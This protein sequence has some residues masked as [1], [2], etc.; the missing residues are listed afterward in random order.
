MSEHIRAA[1]EHRLPK[2]IPRG[3][4]WIETRVFAER[5]MEDTIYGHIALYREMEMDFISIP[6]TLSEDSVFSYRMFNPSEIREAAESGLFVLAVVDG[7]FQMLVNR[8]GLRRTL[9]DIAG[10]IDE[11]SET[12]SNEAQKVSS[13]VDTCIH[14]GANAVMIAED[15]AYDRG[16]FFSPTTFRNLLYPAYRD[17]M[18]TIHNC[19]AFAVYHSCGDITG[20]IPDLV[21]LGVDG[22]SCQAE[23]M[24]LLSLKRDY[25]AKLT[26]FT[27]VSLELLDSISI[28]SRHRQQFSKTVTKLGE[29]GGFILSSSSGLSSPHMISNLLQLY[30]IADKTWN[31]RNRIR[32]C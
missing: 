15:I 20:V 24:D 3:E 25:G 14:Y 21:S 1:F 12:V 31:R 32:T 5:Q 6:V 7:P 17:L 23:C 26:M 16:T 19:G 28:L 2:R 27:G 9:A 29:G 18:N 30:G 4:F 11:I 8:M 10:R 22:L 13:L